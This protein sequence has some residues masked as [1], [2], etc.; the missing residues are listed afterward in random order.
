MY[1]KNYGHRQDARELYAGLPEA[2]RFTACTSCG[3]CQQACPNRLAIVGKLEEAHG[4]LS[5]A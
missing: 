1:Y 4:L 3:L 2:K 5:T